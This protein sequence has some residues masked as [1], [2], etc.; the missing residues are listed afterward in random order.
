MTLTDIAEEVG[1]SISYISRL[2]KQDERYCEEQQRRK[3]ENRNKRKIKQRELM[4]KI[5]KEKAML[6]TIENQALKNMHNQ[7][8]AEMST[9]K[10]IGN[11]ILRKWCSLYKYNK[12]KNCYEFDTKKA[13]KP[14]D[15]PLYIKA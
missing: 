13:L 14:N 10:V 9:G 8:A 11:E 3:K 5:R 12:E 6:R 2:L 4:R 1:L 7:A 15:F